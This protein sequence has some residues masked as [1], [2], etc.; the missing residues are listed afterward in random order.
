MDLSFP[1]LVD[2]GAS[3][4]NAS[5]AVSYRSRDNRTFGAY[6]KNTNRVLGATTEYVPGYPLLELQTDRAL[7]WGN[8]LNTDES[9][10]ELHTGPYLAEDD[11]DLGAEEGPIHWDLPSSPRIVDLE[12]LQARTVPNFAQTMDPTMTDSPTA[13]L[14]LQAPSQRVQKPTKPAS[15]EDWVKHRPLITRLYGKMTLR[16]V[17]QYMTKEHGFITSERAYKRRI[18]EWG[19]DKNNKEK[20]MRAIVRKFAQ[21]K[22][23]HKSSKFRVR[24]QEVDYSEIVRYFARKGVS[25]DDVMAR[26]KTSATPEAVIC[27]TPLQ[28]P[29]VTPQVYAIPECIFAT[30]RDYMNGSFDSGT[31]IKTDQRENC[32]S[33]KEGTDHTTSSAL[34][35]LDIFYSCSLEV[36]YLHELHENGKAKTSQDSAIAALRHVLPLELPQT[37]LSVFMLIAK[38]S[39][40]FRKPGVASA[41]IHTITSPGELLLYQQHPLPTV[42]KAFCRLNESEFREIS[43]KCLRAMAEGFGNNLGSM[44]LVSLGAYSIEATSDSLRELLQRCQ[45]EIGIHDIRTIGVRIRLLE[46]LLGERRYQLAR[47]ECHNLLA[48]VHMVQPPKFMLRRRTQG[49]CFLAQIQKMLSNRDLAVTTLREAIA[50]RICAWGS[51]DVGVRARILELRRWLIELGRNEEV[52]E[53]QLWYDM[54]RNAPPELQQ[55]AGM[56][57]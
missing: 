16:K 11:L 28:S 17:M 30:L 37:L 19:L 12:V 40:R 3:H 1:D 50:V 46:K 2:N 8:M 41:L 24:D 42:A 22:A 36:C 33:I 34:H 26:R 45:A 49:L 48:T 21:R 9:L 55:R 7:D 4:T 47:Q 20:E 25:I 23:N 57:M 38:L 27:F 52:A 44:H 43:I 10:T 29:I 15:K 6:D 13:L 54:I 56:V 53:V 39:N 51:A 18:K 31:W 35:C 14:R 5:D 32:Y